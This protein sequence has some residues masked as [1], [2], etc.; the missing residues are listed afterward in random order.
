MWKVLFSL[1]W[2][3]IIEQF[4]LTMVSYVDTA[5]VG[6]LGAQATAAIAINASTTWLINGVLTAIGCVFCDT[7]VYGGYKNADAAEYADQSYKCDS[8][9]LVDLSYKKTDFFGTV[10]Y[11][12]GSGFGSERCSDSFYDFHDIDGSFTGIDRFYS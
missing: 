2:P 8:E 1:A 4:L 5:M 10:F 3:A 11:N 7:A 9:F 6:S 12:V